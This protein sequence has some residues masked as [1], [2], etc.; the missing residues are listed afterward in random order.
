MFYILYLTDM[1]KSLSCMKLRFT[2]FKIKIC[3]FFYANLVFA[4]GCEKPQNS[5]SLVRIHEKPRERCVCVCAYVWLFYLFLYEVN[6]ARKCLLTMRLMACNC[7]GTHTFPHRLAEQSE[8]SLLAFF[9]RSSVSRLESTLIDLFASLVYS[10]T[11]SWDIGHSRIKPDKNHPSVC[12]LISFRT[13]VN[14][15]RSIALKGLSRTV[16]IRL[17]SQKK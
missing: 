5:H 1:R 14:S 3:K 9:S 11:L 10:L 4:W 12:P 15:N 8:L 6:I 16:L 7:V 17:T 13:A 2:L